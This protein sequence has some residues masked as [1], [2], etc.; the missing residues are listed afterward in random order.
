[1]L[2]LDSSTPSRPLSPRMRTLKSESFLKQTRM[3]RAIRL[4]K[5]LI[6]RQRPTKR[7]EEKKLKEPRR[8]LVRKPKQLPMMV[9]P[10][11]L[12]VPPSR[13]KWRSLA[14]ST[15]CMLEFDCLVNSI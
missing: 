6:R 3:S 2:R 11:N 10:Q 5:Q 9:F 13:P 14:S 8:L 7:P 15:P 1:M 4:K 12:Q